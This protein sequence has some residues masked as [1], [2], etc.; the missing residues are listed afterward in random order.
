M[1]WKEVLPPSDEVRILGNPPFVG[2]TYQ[3]KEQKEDIQNIFV[4]EKGKKYKAIG[5]LDYVSCWYFKA[6]EYMQGT[7]IEAAFVSTNSITQGE[8]ASTVWQPIMERF[9]I[10]INFAWRTFVWTSESKD[11]AAVHCVII[12]FSQKEATEKWLYDDGIKAAATNINS[13]L[14]N[15]PTIFVTSRTS[16]LCDV[17]KMLSGNRPADGGNLIIEAEDYDD[18][19]KREPDAKKYIKK[20]AM[21]REYINNLP[22]YCLW[23]VNADPKELRKMPLV[24]ARIKA[25]REDRLKG[26]ADRQKL[27]DTP[28]LFR[29][30]LNPSHFIAIPKVSSENRRYI[31]MGYLGNDTI[32]GD[33]LFIIPEATLYHFGILMSN[34]HMAWMRA[35]CGRLKSDYS[36]SINIVYNNFPWPTPTPEQ[37]AAIEKAAQGIL[38]ARNLH[39]HDS[40]ADLYDEVLMPKELREAH[41]AN[42]RAVMQAYGFS[43]KMT[44]ADCVAALMKRYEE[45]TSGAQA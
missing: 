38:N 5:K 11:Q 15:A 10:H 31:P 21:G 12:G 33:K 13:Y 19:I 43:T 36:Y 2:Y 30:Q 42:D 45:L 39:P 32:A 20:F 6:A 41:R 18:F 4:D 34:V 3:T 23:L 14:M 1:D 25:C 37:K 35:V 44:E 28:S 7:N 16:P 9:G 17:P 40:L 8:Q 24:M 22:R 29:E 27:A 26:A